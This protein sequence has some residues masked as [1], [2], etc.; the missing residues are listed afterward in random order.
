MAGTIVPQV[1]IEN[2]DTSVKT[3]AMDV[4]MPSPYADEGDDFEDAGDL[5]FSQAQQQ[6]WLSHVPRSLWEALSKLEDD[7][8]IDL[9]TVRVEGPEDNPQRVSD[10]CVHSTNAWLTSPRSS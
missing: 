8:E 9:G 2:A 3:E 6:L 7:D 1:K 5:D 10:I 4:D